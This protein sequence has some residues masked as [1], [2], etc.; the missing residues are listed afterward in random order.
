MFCVMVTLAEILAGVNVAQ[1][2][3]AG[4]AIYGIGQQIGK[5]RPK[6][7]R[8]HDFNR[9]VGGKFPAQ[10]RHQL[11]I[12]L[13]GHHAGGLGSQESCQR[14]LPRPDF[15]HMVVGCKL[16]RIYDAGQNVP[17]RKEILSEGFFRPYPLH[18]HRARTA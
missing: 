5:V 10:E 15:E 18:C 6:D 7:I 14:S 2:E 11:A 13:H 9:P 4:R 1:E 12:K 17:V 3:L 8:F 16:Y